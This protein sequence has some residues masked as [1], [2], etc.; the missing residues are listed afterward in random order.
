[1]QGRKPTRSEWKIFERRGLDSRDYLV[2]KAT[3]NYLQVVNKATGKEL[4][5]R[6]DTS[7][8]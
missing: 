1:M 7:E 4:T 5:I 6:I 2:Q 8:V 3:N